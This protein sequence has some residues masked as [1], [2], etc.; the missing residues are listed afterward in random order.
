VGVP[1]VMQMT[2]TGFCMV[3]D[4]AREI[5]MGCSTLRS[6]AVPRGV[7]P[8]TRHAF[9]VHANLQETVRSALYPSTPKNVVSSGLICQIQL[10]WPSQSRKMSS[11]PCSVRTKD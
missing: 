6:R 1:S 4:L 11:C 3:L 2:S 5:T 8:V 10:Q 9:T 7:V